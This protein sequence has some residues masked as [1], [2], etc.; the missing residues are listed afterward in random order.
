M[1][2]A[3]LTLFPEMFSS[4]LE[5][6]LL[7]KARK[8]EI[9]EIEVHNLRKWTR[10]KHKIADDRP[11]GGGVGMLLK[12]EPIYAAL[13]DLKGTTILLSPQGKIFN[14]AKAIQLSQRKSIILVCGHYE[15]VD[16]RVSR[17]VDE[18]VSIGDFVLTGGELPALV[19]I[20]AVVRLLPGVVGRKRSLKEESFTQK[21]LD[22]P[23]YTRPANFRGYKVPQ[24]LLSGNHREIA[25]WRKKEA[26][27]AT[28]RKRPELI[29]KIKFSFLEKKLFKEVIAEENGD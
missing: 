26:I 14:Q 22:W 13:Q 5:A 7:G 15:G 29:D 10:D 24:V 6:S 4:V 18:E 20:D 11:Y 28:W 16:E 25:L 12:L 8:K 27:R 17:F 23:H 1:K 19:I 3:V 21:F 2:I 9:V